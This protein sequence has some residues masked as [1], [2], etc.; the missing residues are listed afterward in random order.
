MSS[1]TAVV[2]GGGIGGLATAV[3]LHRIGW[4]A[5]VLEQAPAISRINE[6]R[7]VHASSVRAAVRREVNGRRLAT[8]ISLG[9]EREGSPCPL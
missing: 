6:I 9:Q 5:V 1:G 4:S 2:V 7:G 8:R 3:G